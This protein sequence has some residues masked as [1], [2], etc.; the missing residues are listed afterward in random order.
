[1]RLWLGL[2]FVALCLWELLFFENVLTQVEF[3]FETKSLFITAYYVFVTLFGFLSLTLLFFVRSRLLFALFTLFTLVSYLVDLT[4]KNINKMGFSLNDL[5]VAFAEADKFA[6]DALRAYAEPLKEASLFVFLLFVLMLIVRAIVKKRAYL[7]ST[8][9]VFGS[10]VFALL[11]SYSVIFK[12]TGATQTRPTSIKLLNTI[13]YSFANSLYYGEREVLKQMPKNLAEYKNI[14]LIVDESIGG[15]YL[16]I[17]GY[18]KETTPYL[19]SIEKKFVNLGIASSGAN[20]SATSNLILMSGL[21]LQE[22]PDKENSSLK[23]PTIFAYAK[24]AGF[25]THYISGQGLGMHF[26]NHMS[27]YD[28]AQIDN[29]VQ[30]KEAYHNGSMPEERVILETKKALKSSSK[31]FIFMVKHGSHFQWEQSY[32][33]TEKYFVP[34]LNETEALKLSRKKEALNSYLN[35]VKYNVD[36]FFKEFLDE[37]AFDKMKNTLIIYT[38]DHGQSILEEGRTSTHCDSTNPPLT[39][40]VVPLLLFSSADKSLEQ[41]HFQKD[42]YSHYEIFPTIQKLMGYTK[43]NGKT[44]FEVDKNAKQVFVSGDIF[45]R[46]MLQRNSIGRE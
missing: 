16:S 42:I 1:M 28:L 18:E 10:F 40:G 31:N 41:Y 39:Q 13:I 7:V 27:K 6:L 32:P 14:I 21:Q 30:P 46:V 22:L 3:L 44:L 5:S 20:C 24:N 38:S 23:K 9:L 45:G 29:F 2:V 17:N 34:T 43:L 35:S 25:K 8:K 26:Q 33:Q 11:L 12:T 15:K 36:L 4:Y 37:I 19:K